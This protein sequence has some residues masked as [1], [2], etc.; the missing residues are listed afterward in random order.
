[1]WMIKLGSDQLYNTKTVGIFE[2]DKKHETD[3]LAWKFRFHPTREAQ[4]TVAANWTPV[5]SNAPLK[6]TQ[7]V[8]TPPPY[9][10]RKI[11]VWW[12]WW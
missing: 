4:G 8:E 3:L 11:N 6:S 5:P 2:A 9:I 1:M 10:Y 7:Y 12:W